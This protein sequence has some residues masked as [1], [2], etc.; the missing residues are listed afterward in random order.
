MKENFRSSEYPKNY[1]YKRR[2]NGKDIWFARESEMLFHDWVIECLDGKVMEVK[3][4]HYDDLPQVQ[5]RTEWVD[6]LT[7][8]NMNKPIKLYITD[9]GEV[10]LEK[11]EKEENYK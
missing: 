1:K 4:K 6:T 9:T 8:M 7:A 2:A 11:F 5:P 3:L 10:I